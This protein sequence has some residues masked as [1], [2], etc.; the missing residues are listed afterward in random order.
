MTAMNLRFLS[1]VYAAL[2]D[3]DL[4]RLAA[5]FEPEAYG[6]VLGTSRL[7]GD[8]YGPDG[9]AGLFR[10]MLT[11]SDGTL[12][13]DVCNLQANAHHGLALVQAHAR[14]RDQVLH[15]LELHLFHLYA[16]D[17]GPVFT[18]WIHPFDPYAFD[19]FWS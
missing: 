16:H 8:Y 2:G 13:Y 14:H 19:R 15:V 6:R 5:V 17:R 12:R 7:A 10:Q 11:L 3:R 1:D 4:R 9:V 18:F